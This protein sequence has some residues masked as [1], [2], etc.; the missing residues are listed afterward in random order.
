M[1]EASEERFDVRSY[2]REAWNRQVAGGQ[3]QWTK[4]VG[5][6]V[7]AAA[8]KGD[9]QIVLTPQ[10]PV[11]RTWFGPAFPN[12]DILCLASGGGQQGPVLAA[13]GARVTVFDN[14]PAQLAQDRMVADRDG[15]TLDKIKALTGLLTIDEGDKDALHMLITGGTQPFAALVRAQAIHAIQRMTGKMWYR[16][17]PWENEDWYGKDIREWWET[18]KDTWVAPEK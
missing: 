10:K 11:P 14:S 1:N 9:W 12:L 8:A 2:N 13:A 6:E 17:A 3:N 18:A 7:T 15:L 16:A 5:P 4:P